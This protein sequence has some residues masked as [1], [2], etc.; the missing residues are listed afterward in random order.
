MKIETVGLLSIPADQC[1][2]HHLTREA[3]AFRPM[4]TN[5]LRLL[6]DRDAG[7]T[8]ALFGAASLWPCS[9]RTCSGGLRGR[10]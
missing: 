3:P 5:R 1:H 9:N 10:I 7:R 4:R 8:L 6:P 2:S